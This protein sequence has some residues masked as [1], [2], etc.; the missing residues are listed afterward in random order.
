[1]LHIKLVKTIAESIAEKA[2]NFIRPERYQV[3]HRE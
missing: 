1:M 3:Q 2:I